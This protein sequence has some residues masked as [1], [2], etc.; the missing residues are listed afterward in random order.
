VIFPSGATRE[1]GILEL[2]HSKVLLSVSVPSLGG[3]LYYVTFIDYF[4]RNTSIYFLSKK[5]KVF[6]KLKE[7]EYLVENQTYNKIKVLRTDNGG[8]LCVK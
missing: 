3:S 8:E 5:S 4:S 1:N 2:V 6:Y 7:F